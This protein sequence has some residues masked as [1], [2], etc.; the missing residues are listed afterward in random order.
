MFHARS[1]ALVAAIVSG[2]NGSI[3]TAQVTTYGEDPVPRSNEV[4]ESFRGYGIDPIPPTRFENS[5]YLR[6]YGFD[7]VPGRIRGA[8]MHR[9]LPYQSLE[10][11]TGDR[12][13]LPTPAGKGR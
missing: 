11:L 12:E 6:A 4:F 10:V 2:P 3:A 1:L 5:A 9:I 13:Y 7:P 8:D